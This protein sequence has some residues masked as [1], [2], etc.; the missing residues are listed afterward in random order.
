MIL[1]DTNVI[2]N[3]WKKPDKDNIEIFENEDIA[4]Y[5]IIK[6]ELIH[7]AKT[8]KEID[9]IIESLADFTFF[10]IKDND[11]IEIGK[12]L[13][14]LKK[15]GITVP[16]QDAVL[17][18]LSIKNNTFFWTYDNHFD[19]IKKEIPQLKLFKY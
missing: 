7:G 8:D 4:T 17:T 16:F 10:E 2:I 3:F 13:N 6:A 19:L 15:N 9:L 14:L 18:F 12:I 5:G 1:V 11:W